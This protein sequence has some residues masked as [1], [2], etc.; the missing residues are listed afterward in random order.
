MITIH[1]FLAALGGV[2]N[3]AT[4]SVMA[5]TFGFAMLPSALAYLV[6]I[7]GCVVFNSA[8]PISFQAET[9]AMAGTMGK[10][11]NERL[12][13]VI[14]AGIGMSVLGALGLLE[15]IVKF[16][17]GHVTAAMMAG[18]GLIL[19]KISVDMVRGDHKLG[20][21]SMGVGILSYL[22][23]RDLVY[24]CLFSIAASSIAYHFSKGNAVKNIEIEDRFSFQLPA[25]SANI[26]RGTLALM[27]ITIGG[28]IAFGQVSGAISGVDVN[29][30]H[31]SIY[32]G[33]ADAA[34]SLFGGSPISVVIS[35][36]AAAPNAKWAAVIMMAIMALILLSRQLPKIVRFI[37]SSAV[38]GT[39]FIL[40]A[41]LTLPSNLQAAYADAAP[42]TALASSVALTVTVFTDPFFGLAA[43]ILVN[44]LA[45]PLGLG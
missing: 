31:I 37:P 4:Q 40:G 22:I 7:A 39:L 44:L 23:T 32:S 3:G 17:G 43:G 27:C 35:P 6:G 38:A 8:V 10:T 15:G 12:S 42:G 21:I 14:L 1:D 25:F 5:M 24:T 30:D 29:V 41:V 33:L 34:S 26:L 18:V 2:L 16:A 45:V 20:S 28:N 13:M 36:T 9:M 11:R 19:A